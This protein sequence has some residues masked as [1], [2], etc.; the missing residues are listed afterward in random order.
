MTY[1]TRSVDLLRMLNVAD[2]KEEQSESSFFTSLPAP[3]YFCG[4]CM[5]SCALKGANGPRTV[6][7]EHR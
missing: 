5:C 2:V 6:F 1:Y 7:Q 4:D 3:R